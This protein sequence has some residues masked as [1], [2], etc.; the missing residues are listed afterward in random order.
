M[1]KNTI[2]SKITAIVGHGNFRV[3]GHTLIFPNGGLDDGAVRQ[4]ESKGLSLSPLVMIGTGQA[5]HVSQFGQ[6]P[7]RKEEA[8]PCRR[9]VFLRR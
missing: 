6:K 5:F 7:T 1:N 3:D 2:V 9:P 8:Q 4:L